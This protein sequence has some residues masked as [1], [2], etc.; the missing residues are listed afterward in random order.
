MA[1]YN[2]H[3]G[4]AMY[5]SGYAYGA[6]GILNE[7]N[8][9][10]TVKNEVIRLLKVEGHTVYDCTVDN[11][12]TKNGCL[13]SI[14]KKCNAHDVTLDVS[15]HLNSGRNDYSGDNS[16]GGCEVYNYDTRTKAISDRIN[17]NI[18]NA[19]GIRNRGTKYEPNFYVLANTNSLAILVECC[20]VDDK[21]DVNKWDA[22]KCAKAIVEGI[23]NKSVSSVTPSSSSSTTTQLYRVRA[24]WDNVKSQLG[25][26]SVLDNAKKNC[27]SGY[28][29]YDWNGNVVYSNV[30]ESTN[31]NSQLYRV[32][33]TW[34]DAKSQKGAYK[35]LANAKATCDANYG[36]S[37]FDESGNAV[38]TSKASTEK[39]EVKE[40]TITPEVKPE[41]PE[42]VDI[43]PLKGMD[44]DA[45]IKYLGALAKADMK[46]TGVLASVTLAQAILESGWGQSELSLK[47]NNLF[48]MKSTLSGNTWSS[49]WDGRIYAKRSN[50]EYNGVATSVLSDFR[51]YDDVAAS[52][53]DHSDYLCGAKNGSKLRY[54]GLKGETDYRTAIQ[55]IKDS[56]YATDS[57]YVNKICTLIEQYELDKWDEISDIIEE[58]P[59]D[60]EQNDD[61][62]EPDK[63]D[64]L[65][66][67]V[68]K[69]Y[70][71]LE[72]ILNIITK[73]FE[74]LS[75]VFK[76]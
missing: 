12:T 38:Y 27:P 67:K 15:I 18:S 14:V 26:Y 2:V 45:L 42:A 57:G 63:V 34:A 21:D 51:A 28:N 41:A 43:S 74:F 33:L 54:E 70:T 50:E 72:A 19:L 11:A 36:Y 75:S 7:S 64:E 6:V 60:K 39:E 13:A 32:R 40:E 22:K 73:I 31:T 8:E 52:I 1:I 62:V 59:V 47:A 35:E 61:V 66:D 17:K 29:V 20:F 37:V 46:K 68:N 69:T 44:Q 76:K 56:G 65:V 55:I 53:K 48:G 16:T 9:A 10:R 23:L 58:V 3:A 4:H 71:V 49:E 24:S 25:A 30:Q 5:K